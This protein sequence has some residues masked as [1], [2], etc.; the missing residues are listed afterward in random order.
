MK[1]GRCE[2][3]SGYL[4]QLGYDLSPLGG[5]LLIGDR[6]LVQKLAERLD[7]AKGR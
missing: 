6:R 4:R 3:L 2:L 5:A 7:L 1:G